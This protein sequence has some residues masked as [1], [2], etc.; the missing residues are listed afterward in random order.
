MNAQTDSVWVEGRVTDAATSR[1]QTSCE[2]QL[3]QEGAARAVAFCDD[4]G[5]YTIGWMPTGRYTLSILS[6]GSSLYIAEI[7]LT[8]SI[9]M[10]IALMPDTVNLRAL[11]PIAVNGRKHQLGEKLITS[12]D[13]RRLWNFSGVEALM[14]SGP[15]SADLSWPGGNNPFW[16]SGLRSWRPAWLDAPWTVKRKKEKSEKP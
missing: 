8:E 15:A 1:P 2:V 4:E 3:L 5:Y 7:H 11:D 12:P 16:S 10:N 6:G 14:D 13:D 9:M